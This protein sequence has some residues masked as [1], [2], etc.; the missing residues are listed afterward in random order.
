[1]TVLRPFNTFGPRQ[2]TRAIIPTLITQFHKKSARIKVGSLHP[3]R[4]FTFVT[5]TAA[6]F[7]A[8]AGAEQALGR[9]I[10]LGSNFQV[11]VGDLVEILS[12][13][14]GHKPEVEV[15]HERIRPE[16]S[17]V[18]RL[19]ADNFLAKQLLGW[20]P[21]FGG[22]DG[23]E[24]ALLKTVEWFSDPINLGHYRISSYTV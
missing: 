5:D 8:A 3:T 4:D 15:E 21:R 11:S 9:T 10:Q 23:F 1:V 6:G 20:S 19:H 22:R 12:S 16:K 2:S 14:T 24:Q 18:Q 17:E 7:I 13:I